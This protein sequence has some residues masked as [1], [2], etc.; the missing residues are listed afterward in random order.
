MTLHVNELTFMPGGGGV[1]DG[2]RAR[3]LPSERPTVRDDVLA[4]VV[5]KA[6]D[7]FNETFGHFQVSLLQQKKVNQN[8]N[9]T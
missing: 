8:M 4:F 3:H 1:G 7:I 6:Q 2:V 9:S 5:V